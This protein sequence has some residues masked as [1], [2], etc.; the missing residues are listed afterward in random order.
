MKY[1]KSS[2]A[3]LDTCDIR[4]QRV[5]DLALSWGLIDISV[6]YGERKPPEQ[7]HIF[8]KGRERAQHTGKAQKFDSLRTINT[9]GEF[10][11][12]DGLWHIKDRSKVV[13]FKD[14]FVN[15][16]THN[17][18]PSLAV[19]AAPFIAGRVRYGNTEMEL[20]QVLIMAGIIQAAF[21]VLNI[22]FTW[23]GN[24]DGDGEPL[25][26][27]TFQDLLHFQVPKEIA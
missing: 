19:D 22:E 12:W 9:N 7:F 6:I 11:D 27:Q 8:T 23:G 10:P 20:K 24:W 18:S 5:M 25:S 21:K 26:D 15:L 2:Q 4:I 13:T 16:S 3:K 17:N 14:G 1:G